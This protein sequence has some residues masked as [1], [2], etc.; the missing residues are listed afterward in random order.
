MFYCALP[1][2]YI[3]KNYKLAYDMNSDE[4]ELFDLKKD[5]NEMVNHWADP[6]YKEIKSTLLLKALQAKMKAEPVLMPRTAG[7]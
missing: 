1:I 4:G 2:S 3:D 5:P 7:A 6:A